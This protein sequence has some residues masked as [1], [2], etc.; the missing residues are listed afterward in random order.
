MALVV[1]ACSPVKE[2]ARTSAKLSQNGQDSS[3]YEILIIDPRFDQWY[4]LNYSPT[5]DYSND[6]YRS[7][8]LAAVTNWDE[9]YHTGRYNRVIDSSID[10]WPNIDYG[11]EVN[12]K[13]YWYFKYVQN[14]YRIRLF[15]QPSDFL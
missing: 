1:W 4:L 7:K 15:L 9:Y 2:A 13:L 10:Y 8:N 3:G 12:R 11:I 6:Y 14:N 5:K